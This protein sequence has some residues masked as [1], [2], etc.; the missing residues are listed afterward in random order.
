MVVYTGGLVGQDFAYV[1]FVAC[2]AVLQHYWMGGQVG[3]MRKKH[4]VRYPDMYATPRDQQSIRSSDEE[5]PVTQKYDFFD[6][7]FI[8]FHLTTPLLTH[9]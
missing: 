8:S 9:N 2:A 6:H 3:K 5:A 1:L 7:M 4:D